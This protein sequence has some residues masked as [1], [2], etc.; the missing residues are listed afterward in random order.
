MARLKGSG[1]RTSGCR[2]RLADEIA[3][4]W[5]DARAYWEAFQRRLNRLPEDDPATSVTRE[6]WII[7]LLGSLGYESLVYQPRAAH[8]DGSTFAI[9]HRAGP[10]EDALPVHIE[11]C[12]IDLRDLGYRIIVTRYDQDLE[13]QIQQC[14]DVFG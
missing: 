14:P 10:D 5:G 1:R 13:E 6:Q 9:S 11:G 2:A 8:V 7:P 12:R 4:A 3:V